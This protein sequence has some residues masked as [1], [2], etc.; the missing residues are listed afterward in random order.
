MLEV[1]PLAPADWEYFCLDGV[2]Y[3]G[4]TLTILYD[5]SGNRYGRGAGLRILIDGAEA[6][7]A[8]TIQRITVALE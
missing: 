5:R 3:H 2:V 1:N 8:A 6:A 7:R 4:R